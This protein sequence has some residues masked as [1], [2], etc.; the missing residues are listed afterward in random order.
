ML[1][2]AP[3]VIGENARGRLVPV[4]DAQALEEAIAELA[5]DPPRARRLARAGRKH[6]L[7][8]LSPACMARAYEEIYLD[9]YESSGGPPA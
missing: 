5:G 7:E 3:D 1:R 6:A 9:A 2:I 4:A 8:S